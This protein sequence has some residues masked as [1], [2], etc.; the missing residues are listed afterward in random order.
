M[1]RTAM[2]RTGRLRP[3][4]AKVRAG[5][6]AFKA[7]YREV[8]QRSGGRCEYRARIAGDRRN[9]ERVIVSHQALLRAKTTARLADDFATVGEPGHAGVVPA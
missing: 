7:V 4:S 2:K 1:K 9:A 3:Q 6:D 5:A 8:D